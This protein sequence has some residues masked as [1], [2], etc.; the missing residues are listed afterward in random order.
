M[1]LR[2]RLFNRE[3]AQCILTNTTWAIGHVRIV[4]CTKAWCAFVQNNQK[5]LLWCALVT[6][7]CGRWTSGF[8]NVE[9]ELR[10]T[11]KQLNKTVFFVSS[12]LS[13]ALPLF[14][15]Q[16]ITSN[17]TESVNVDASKELASEIPSVT[18]RKKKVWLHIRRQHVE[19]KLL[20]MV[21]FIC[22]T[23][24]LACSVLCFS[25]ECSSLDLLLKPVSN[26]ASQQKNLKK[27]FLF[28]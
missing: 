28:C 5:F 6:R 11:V 9:T 16:V 12:L 2:E 4:W 17:A 3:H 13:F 14:C 7:W 20:Y 26:M 15:F 8:Q 23:K 21:L 19:C 24:L 22:E 1:F 27:L 10:N 18:P 25:G